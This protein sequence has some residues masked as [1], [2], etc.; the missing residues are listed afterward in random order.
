MTKTT[1]ER[2]T[3]PSILQNSKTHGLG[4][5]T[6]LSTKYDEHS[7]YIPPVII[8]L[9]HGVYLEMVRKKPKGGFFFP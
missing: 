8:C 9:Q 1:R 3:L 5:Y 6:L 4:A 7:V 2:R